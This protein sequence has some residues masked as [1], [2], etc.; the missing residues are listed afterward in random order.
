VVTPPLTIEIQLQSTKGPPIVQLDDRRAF[1]LL[2]AR[3]TK[4]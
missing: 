1:G 2:M 4:D 3:V